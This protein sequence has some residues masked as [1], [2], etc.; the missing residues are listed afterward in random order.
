MRSRFPICLA[1][2]GC[3]AAQV[4]PAAARPVRKASS[5]VRTAAAP[6]Q[7]VLTEGLCRYT[8]SQG[9]EPQDEVRFLFQGTEVTLPRR[10][11]V[12]PVVVERDF[13][14]DLP[15]GAPQGER[16]VY[17]H[18]VTRFDVATDSALPGDSGPKR[19]ERPRLAPGMP[20]GRETEALGLPWLSLPTPHAGLTWERTEALDFPHL[21][22]RFRYHVAGLTT[23]GGRR[24]WRVECALLGDPAKP[25]PVKELKTPATVKQWQETFWVDATGQTLLRLERRLRLASTDPQPF[26]LSLEL[27]WT[28]KATRPLVAAEYRARI[29]FYNRLAELESKIQEAGARTTLDGASDL[30][31]LQSKVDDLR[32]GFPHR[33]YELLF[34][35][36]NAWIQSSLQN[37]EAREKPDKQAG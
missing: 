12:T 29:G 30:R 1:A 27:A 24:A 22:G 6:P 21:R 37:F 8:I 17:A 3:V 5:P 11:A 34:D 2:A 25:R 13:R 19:W 31:E 14:P 36:L 26:E 18:E 9:G 28:R 23:I 33:R 32:E 35:K 7:E 4:S 16:Q 20:P 15:Y 10:G